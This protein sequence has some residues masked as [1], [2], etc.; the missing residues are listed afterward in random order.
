MTGVPAK[1]HTHTHSGKLPLTTAGS[2]FPKV[3][4]S[5]PQIYIYKI[6]CFWIFWQHFLS[7]PSLFCFRFICHG[8]LTGENYVFRV[9]AVNAAGLSEYSQESEAIE[10]KAAIGKRHSIAMGNRKQKIE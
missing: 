8:L 7:V 3:L 1:I 4:P 10:V 9:R 2:G 5:P 6:S